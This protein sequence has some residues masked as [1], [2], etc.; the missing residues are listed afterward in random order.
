ML[1]NYCEK[2]PVAP[3]YNYSCIEC[4]YTCKEC[5]EVKPY[6]NGSTCCPMCDECHAE[7]QV[8]H[9]S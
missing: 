5:G 2:N 1:C 8:M 9:A 4:T 6:E 3:K 7:L